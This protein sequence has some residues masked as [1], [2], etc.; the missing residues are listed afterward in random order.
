MY[1]PNFHYLFSA[2]EV[3]VLN[4]DPLFTDSLT[5]QSLSDETRSNALK[6]LTSAEGEILM[7]TSLNFENDVRRKALI[8]NYK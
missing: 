6:I 7:Y 3:S 2:K 4:F 5:N 8:H 1:D